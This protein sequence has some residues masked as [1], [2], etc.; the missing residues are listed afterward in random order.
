MTWLAGVDGCKAGWV[1]V[2]GRFD[3]GVC[4]PL[5]VRIARDLDAVCAQGRNPERV[6]L[7]MPVGLLEARRTGG[8]ECDQETRKRLK[9]RASSVFSPPV[10]PL[11][12]AQS[13]D[14]ARGGG[15][16]IQAWGIVPKIRAVD[17]WMTP[18]RQERVFEAHP[19]LAFAL[20]AGAPMN[21]NKAKPE[22]RAERL[23]LLRRFLPEV[24]RLVEPHPFLKK[25]V[26]GDD[27][28]DACV[29]L[30]V[31]HAHLLG[32]ATVLP[33]HR[34]RDARGLEMVI[35]GPSP[36]SDPPRQLG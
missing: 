14:E 28:L 6:A 17:Q 20:L 8:R 4:G 18:Q 26:A 10:R 31:A 15:I 24:D 2:E 13:W 21:H 34:P 7:D 23:A 27:L 22:G 32:T 12:Q 29:L 30:L 19:E 9:K 1:V 11:L 16:S 35:W 25:D 36:C 33:A 3:G 5:E